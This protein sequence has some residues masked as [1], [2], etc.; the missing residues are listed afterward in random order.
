VVGDAATV[1]AASA[2]ADST[3]ATIHTANS[4]V[5]VPT[6]NSTVADPTLG[7]LPKHAAV[8]TAIAAELRTGDEGPT[9]DVGELPQPQPRELGC[10]LA[11]IRD[12]T[13]PATKKVQDHNMN[14]VRNR[15]NGLS[16]V[17]TPTSVPPPSSVPPPVSP[18]PC[19]ALLKAVEQLDFN[20]E[21]VICVHASIIAAAN[22]VGVGRQNI[23]DCCRVLGDQKSSGGYKWRFATATTRVVE[24]LDLNTES[25]IC[26]HASV[27]SAANAVGAHI[28]S[29]SACCRGET[30][31][32]C[33]YKWRYATLATTPEQPLPL[34]TAPSAGA[35]SRLQCRKD[36]KGSRAVEQLDFN[37]ESVICVHAS[38]KSAADVVGAQPQNISACC[39]GEKPSSRSYKWRYATLAETPEQPPTQSY[40]RMQQ[41]LFL[42]RT[43][44][45]SKTLKMMSITSAIDPANG[46]T[47]AHAYRC[48][49]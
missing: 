4:T 32:F 2:V 6:T 49:T 31:F 19:S 47:C 35:T 14:N 25:V 11:D 30:E 27:T 10:L 43:L 9:Q 18:V 24:Q 3:V 38:V 42:K 28:Q 37:T 16:G 7:L 36:D 44:S 17:D 34:S 5:A 20:T 41:P 13:N 48:V 29:I 12:R 23:S 45:N 21:S 22:A 8:D 40:V 33:G 39:R 15:E 26:V 46:A 1:V